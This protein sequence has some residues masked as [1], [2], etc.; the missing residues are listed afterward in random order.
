M[1][2]SNTI[3]IGLRHRITSDERLT[4]READGD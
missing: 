1:A 3:M 2:T 4:H